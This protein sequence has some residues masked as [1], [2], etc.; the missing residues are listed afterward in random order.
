MAAPRCVRCECSGS[1]GP[2][3]TWP[4]RVTARPKRDLWSLGPRRLPSRPPGRAAGTAAAA[5]AAAGHSTARAGAPLPPARRSGSGS[6]RGAQARLGGGGGT[7]GEG[8]GGGG[9]GQAACS[10]ERS[11]GESEAPAPVSVCR[12]G[13]ATAARRP[14]QPGALPRALSSARTCPHPCSEPRGFSVPCTAGVWPFS[15]HLPPR[16]SSHPSAAPPIT[17]SLVVS[18]SSLGDL[19]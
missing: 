10:R 7:R 11:G 5:A 3:G 6:G 14:P 15:Q 16:S 12:R 2:G 4:R 9:G 19:G 8:G 18:C 13:N 1:G 17:G